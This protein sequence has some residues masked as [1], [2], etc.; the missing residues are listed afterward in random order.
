MTVLSLT[1][2]TPEP[3][4]F[5]LPEEQAQEVQEEQPQQDTDPADPASVA[6]EP[7]KPRYRF[8]FRYCLVEFLS[9]STSQ[10]FDVRPCIVEFSRA[11]YRLD[12]AKS[13]DASAGI[14]AV[15][16]QYII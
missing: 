1:E 9:G 3:L 13:G 5:Q 15:L 12:P 14:R 16:G 10:G 7:G 6:P 4:D 8:C 11:L 2:T